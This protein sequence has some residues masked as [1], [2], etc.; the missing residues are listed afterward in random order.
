MIKQRPVPIALTTMHFPV[1]AIVSI[2][3]RLSGVGIF[4]L[5]PVLLY[6]AHLSLSSP[7]GFQQASVDLHR[8]LVRLTLMIFLISL[9]YHFFAGIRHLLMDCRIGEKL[10]AARKSAYIVLFITL[11]YSIF[12]GAWLW[13]GI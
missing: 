10:E 13:L 4:F 5:L 7:A 12:V 2:L 8:P 1:T 6:L 11:I 9:G 3:H